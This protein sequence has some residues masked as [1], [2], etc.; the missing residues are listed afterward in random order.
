MQRVAAESNQLTESPCRDDLEECTVGLG[1]Y[2]DMLIEQL[3]DDAV[4]AR[5]VV[6]ISG[7][8][9][10][11]KTTLA[12]KVYQSLEIRN[13]FEI[14]TWTVLSHKCRAPTSSATSTSR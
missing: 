13:H 8:S 4:A 6:S 14:R 2:S 12:R 1:K 7:E 5:A 3:L 10:I 11:G 9:S